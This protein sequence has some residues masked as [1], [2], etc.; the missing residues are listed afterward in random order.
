MESGKSVGWEWDLKTNRDTWFG[1][2]STMSG[3]PSNI[4]V[5]HVEDFRRFVHPEDRVGVWNA[6]K[7]AME[8][9]SPYS[10]EFRVVWSSGT[11]RRVAARDQFYYSPGGEP[12]RM[13]G[14]AEDVTERKDAEESL[15]LT[16]MELK[17]AQRLAGVGSWQWNPNTDTV[18]WS[19]ELFRIAGRDPSLSAV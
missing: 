3:I 12:E 4:Y 9:R 18:V 1:D 19:E 6:V 13:L 17:E 11:V 7:D 10:A 8:S 2:L 15:R 14:M 16:E 5:G